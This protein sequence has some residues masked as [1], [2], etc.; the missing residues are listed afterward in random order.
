MG[1]DPLDVIRLDVNP[2][3][4]APVVTQIPVDGDWYTALLLP[5][6]V[7]A[8]GYQVLEAKGD[9]TI[10]PH[11]PGM[12]RTLR[13][14]LVEMEGS[15]V[16]GSLLADGLHLRVE[17]GETTYWIEPVEASLPSARPDEY[18]IYRA[19]DV[20]PTNTTCGMA[21]KL[22]GKSLVREGFDA[23]RLRVGGMQGGIAGG[24]CVAELACDADFE[25]FQDYG[26][27]AN[28]ESRVNS[29]INTVNLQYEAQVGITHQIT[30]ILVRSSSNDP[31]TSTDAQ[32]R[33]CQFITEWTNNQG[34]IQRDVAHLFTGAELNGS[35]IG[36]AADI[37]DTGICQNAGGCSGGTFGT[38][39]S[40]CLSQSDFNGNFSCATDL[41]AHELGHL[42]GAFHCSCSGNTMNSGITCANSFSAGT[43]NSITAYRDTRTCLSGSCPGP[44]AGPENDDCADAIPFNGGNGDGAISYS[45]IG[46]NTDGPTNPSGQCNDFGQNQ[47][48]NDI[49]YTY[50]ATCTGALTITTCDDI[51]GFGDP[52]Y[53]TDLVLYGPYGSVG[54]INCGTLSS[55][56]AACNDD[57]A[58]NGCGTSAPYSSTININV[59][60]GEVYL[61]RVGGWNSAESGTGVLE[62]AC[63]GTATGACCFGDG[64]CSILSAG[65]CAGQGGTYQGDGTDCGSANCPQPTGACCFGDGSCS[66]LTAANCSAAGGSY[67]GNGT[68][69]G[70]ANCPQPTGACCF[71]GS[72]Q[73]ET[74]ADCNALGGAYQGDGTDCSPNPCMAPTGACCFGDGSC[75]NLEAA[76]CNAQGGSYQGDGTDCGGVSC[77]QPTGACCFG[78]GSCSEETV[79]DCGALGGSYQ[80]NGTDCGS[81][82]TARSRRG[83]AA[84]ATAPA[85]RR[86][87]R[88]ARASA[89]PTRATARTAVRPTARSRR[90]GRAAS[91]TAP[92]PS[93]CPRTAAASAGPTRVTA[94]IAAA[95]TARPARSRS[96]RRGPRASAAAP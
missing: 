44:P 66:D 8:A 20:H 96:W 88:T 30:T 6:S 19:S 14:H 1:V 21:D 55:N 10:V 79:A 62:V 70:S 89:A 75:Q 22:L 36:I 81:A 35:T 73:I 50:T 60:Q 91:V 58:S 42:W 29:I 16:A 23:E 15:T 85:R 34:S 17:A 54:S 24:A 41:T 92:A 72:C 59:N 4:G 67:Q 83:R 48:W 13:G 33:L 90:R 71:G 61:I 32:S 74:M 37:G 47:T 95:S 27:V 51:H 26:S 64:S 82:S 38:F 31:Y 87:L 56:L 46:A 2:A 78:D 86:P 52:S 7:R 53:D 25:Y 65:A 28:V 77:P 11:A 3:P 43:I 76:D 68:D 94:P 84:S 93:S 80:G 9:G 49:W 63:A 40:Y 18:L 5:H 39:G 57:D 45:T 69:C 12:V